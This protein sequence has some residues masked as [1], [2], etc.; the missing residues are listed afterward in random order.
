MSRPNTF[1]VLNFPVLMFIVVMMTACS[2]SVDEQTLFNKYFMSSR[3]ADNL[4]LS[5]IATVAFSPTVDG[6]MLSF[7]ITLVGPPQTAPLTLREGAEEIRKAVAAE[8]EFTKGKNAFQDS[9]T[10]AIERV[11]KAEAKNQKLGG[12]DLEVQKAWTKW[13]DDAKAMSQKVSAVRKQ[14]NENR[15]FVEI[16]L[17]DSRNP[18]D[19]TAY[20][21]EITT[22]E[23]TIEGRVKVPTGETVTKTYVFTMQRATLKNVNGKDKVGQWVITGRKEAG[24]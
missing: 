13:R 7:S 1:R 8:A 11:L 15:P 21:G 23:V 20:D 19:V 3:I 14:G 16:S 2:G 18:V 4:T 9:N 6:Q 22:K 5:N 17:T 24:K 12:K 10:T